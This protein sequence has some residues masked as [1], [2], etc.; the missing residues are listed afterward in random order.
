MFLDL[1]IIIHVYF[2]LTLWTYSSIFCFNIFLLHCSKNILHVKISIVRFTGPGGVSNMA[3]V[4]VKMV[5]GW[6][7]VKDSLKKVIF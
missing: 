7:P 2:S 3:I 4:D 1:S 6:I 5:T